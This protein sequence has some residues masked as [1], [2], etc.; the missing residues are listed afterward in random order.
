MHPHAVVYILSLR[1]GIYS[2]ESRAH[3]GM[4]HVLCSGFHLWSVQEDASKVIYLGTALVVQRL[5]L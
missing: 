4:D 3:S 1:L 2:E 5:R